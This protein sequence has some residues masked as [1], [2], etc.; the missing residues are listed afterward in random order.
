MNLTRKSK[1]QK[2]C[3]CTQDTRRRKKPNTICVGHHYAQTNTNSVKK[4]QALLQ[5]AG[6]KDKPNIVLC[7]FNNVTYVL[8]T[9]GD[10][11]FSNLRL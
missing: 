7:R 10:S 8:L 4:T 9:M 6:G 11:I 3:I 1:I 5:T 2:L